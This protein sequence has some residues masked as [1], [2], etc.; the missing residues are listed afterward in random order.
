MSDSNT[1]NNKKTKKTEEKQE[2]VMTKYDLKV[3]RRKEEKE[4]EKRDKRIGTIL[5]VLVV[6][7]LVCVVAS[8]PIRTYLTVN[9][10]YVTVG[11][12]KVSRVEFDYHYNLEKNNYISANSMMFYYMGID[13]SS[14]I[15]G[16]MYSED[17]TFKDLFEEMAV[18]SIARNKALIKEA[19]AAGFTY[20]TTE[21]YGEYMDKLKQYASEDGI[22]AKAYIQNLYGVYATE[23]RVKPFVKDAMYANAYYN[24]LLDTMVPTQDEIQQYYEE[25]KANYDSVDYRVLMVDAELPTA[26]TELADP[27][28]TPAPTEGAAADQTPAPSTDPSDGGETAYQPS[29]AEIEAAMAEAKAE[30]EKLEKTVKTE[31]EQKVGIPQSEVLYM[32][33]SWLF[34]DE[35]KAGDTTVIENSSSHRYYV[36][37]FE[38]RYREETLSADIRVIMTADGNGQAILD[39]WKGG[40]ATEASFAELCDKYNDPEAPEGGLYE[41][42]VSS[43]LPD[44]IR[45]WISDSGRASGDTVLLS[46]EGDEY[47]YVIYYVAPNRAEWMISIES[48]LQTQKAEEYTD[49]LIDTM[50]VEDKKG[51]LNYLKVYAAREAAENAQNTEAPAEG[52]DENPSGSAAPAEGS[53]E[54][55]VSSN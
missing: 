13:L 48:T 19:Q 21:E 30:A 46:P 52:S 4:K 11:G 41:A 23:S 25:H 9:G 16:Y 40:A 17:M 14:D 7:A 44:E 26:P 32:L 50:P 8:F 31:G 3:Q 36:L 33:R 51:N 45:N 55:P 38:K 18:D 24:S 47:A 54:N 53:G 2:K 10:T 27:V 1:S 49:A 12:E 15:S 35:R 29:E 28:E 42:M 20:D 39:E 34:D 43:G 5:G 6:A 37:A 22:T